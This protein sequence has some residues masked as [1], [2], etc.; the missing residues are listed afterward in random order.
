[1]NKAFEDIGYLI[2]GLSSCAVIIYYLTTR[3]GLRNSLNFIRSVHYPWHQRNR[4][5]SR[6]SI[7]IEYILELSG[8]M[9]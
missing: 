1:M 2:Y 9:K 8:I 7:C 4:R 3:R 5:Y 6:D